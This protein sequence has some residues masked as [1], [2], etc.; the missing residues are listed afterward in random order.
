V[1]NRHTGSTLDVIS[2][3]AP[4]SMGLL[5][6]FAIC[7]EVTQWR[8]RALFDAIFSAVAKKKTCA[9]ILL[10]NAGWQGHWSFPLWQSVQNDPVWF[11]HT[12]NGFAS[13]ID[14]AAVAEQQRLLPE[15]AFRRYWLNEWTEE[16]EDGIP[17]SLIDA[18]TSPGS[19]PYSLPRELSF[20]VGGVDLALRRNSAAFA[21][22]AVDRSAR[23][24]RTLHVKVWRPPAGGEIDIDSV[25]AHI[26][27]TARRLQIVEVLL[28]PWGSGQLAQRLN[29]RGCYARQI[30]PS[31]GNL[32]V[33]ARTIHEGFR[34][35][36]FTLF[37]YEDGATLVTDL[38]RL[39]I[40]E[41]AG[42]G[43][44]AFRL[45]SPT[46][47]SG[48]HGDAASAWVMPATQA[49]LWLRGM[50]TRLAI[51]DLHREQNAE[52]DKSLWGLPV[53]QVDCPFD[54]KTEF[55]RGGRR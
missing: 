24:V 41:K 28:D 5:L 13:W 22:C 35:G 6:D 2:S 51:E 54:I 44:T 29:K 38:K 7:D 23:K 30:P 32:D 17:P 3:D 55:P 14:P 48:H 50:E 18:V 42:L 4:T 8:D 46:D 20:A 39:S 53:D 9:L 26:L 36:Q 37:S 33:Q 34:E 25:E 27:E 15:S 21:V 49:L 40:V 10:S 19:P 11:A 52:S 31:Q 43:N 45:V 16:N 12:F 47:S 1:V